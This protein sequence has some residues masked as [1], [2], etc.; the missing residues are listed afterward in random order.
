MA[1][2]EV[3]PENLAK[4]A[5]G[6]GFTI[7]AMGPVQTMR[8]CTGNPYEFR[9][10]I[11]Q[12]TYSGGWALVEAMEQILGLAPDAELYKVIVHEGGGC[13]SGWERDAMPGF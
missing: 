1:N 6:R 10:E 13:V 12:Q 8:G 9:S 7:H 4:V 2:F 5:A 3:T 11:N